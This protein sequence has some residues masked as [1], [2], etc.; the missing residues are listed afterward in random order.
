MNLPDPTSPPTNGPKE[1]GTEGHL[2]PPAPRKRVA[3]SWLGFLILKAYYG[4]PAEVM[5]KTMALQAGTMESAA[6]WFATYRAAG[7]HHLVVRLARP[8]LS[9]Y[10]ETVKELLGAARSQ[11]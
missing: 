6:E 9:D 1:V 5:A 8:G 11:L 7:A 10:N 4:V 2:Q 3:L